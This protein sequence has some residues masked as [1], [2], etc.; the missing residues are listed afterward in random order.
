MPTMNDLGEAIGALPKEEKERRRVRVDTATMTV[1]PPA[2]YGLHRIGTVLCYTE[3]Q[4][5]R[6]PTG[7][8]YT[9]HRLTV[10]LR[11]DPRDWIGQ[12]SKAEMDRKSPRKTVTL[13]PLNL[14][15][16]K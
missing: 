10:R 14:R 5:A 13:R 7:G 3:R 16:E 12:I 8:K 6:T 15:G 11:D 9:A 1:Y 4:G 2:G